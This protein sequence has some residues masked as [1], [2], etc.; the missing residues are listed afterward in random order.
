MFSVIVVVSSLFIGIR[1]SDCVWSQRDLAR[2]IVAGCASIVIDVPLVCG[3]WLWLIHISVAVVLLLG[4][5]RSV[6]GHH[7]CQRTAIEYGFRFYLIWFPGVASRNC[8]WSCELV[9]C[10][11]CTSSSVG[12]LTC[13][14][15]C[16]ACVAV[17]NVFAVRVLSHSF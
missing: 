14:H 12:L 11:C 5:H 7:L 2:V 16:L 9:R 13:G 10:L 8:S 1:R 4:G 15:V 6:I 3:C 17:W